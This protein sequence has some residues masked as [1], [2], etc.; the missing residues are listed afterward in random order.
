[1][2]IGLQSKPKSMVLSMGL[3]KVQ[4]CPLLKLNHLP[5]TNLKA[6]RGWSCQINGLAIPSHLNA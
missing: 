5:L 6:M 3:K 4:T 1:M 2:K